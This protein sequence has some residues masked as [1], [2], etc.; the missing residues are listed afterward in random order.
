MKTLNELWAEWQ[1]IEREAGAFENVPEAMSTRQSEIE[2]EMAERVPACL[3][4]IAAQA[5]LV[6]NMVECSSA[7]IDERDVKL[8]HHIVRFLDAL[9]GEGRAQP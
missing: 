6:A 9:T 2:L 5:K 3:P 8:M 7:T 1:D 4:D